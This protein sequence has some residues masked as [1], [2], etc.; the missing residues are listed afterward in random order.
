MTTF[1]N[2]TQQYGTHWHLRIQGIEPELLADLLE[3]LEK[4]LDNLYFTY[5]SGGLE[6]NTL[7]EGL[8]QQHLHLA[9]GTQRST[10]KWPIVNKLGLTDP[11]TKKLYTSWYLTPVYSTSS[12][13]KNRQYC[14]KHGNIVIDKGTLP[15]DD[16]A[17]REI[18]ARATQSRAKEKWTEMIKMAKNQEWNKLELEFP[19]EWINQGAKLKSLYLIQRVPEYR[20]HGNHLWIYGS[21]GTGKSAFVEAYY[22]NH[23][24]KRADKDWLGYNPDLE[25]GHRTVY[26]ADFDP[27]EM[28]KLT[29][30]V[31]KVM[32][33][34]QGFNA[35]KKYAGGDIIC[36]SQIIIT[37]NFR[38]GECFP[39]GVAGVEQQK[40]ALRRRFREVEASTLLQEHGIELKSKLELDQ[41]KN[42][43][44][45][46][47]MK[48][49]VKIAAS[50]LTPI[51]GKKR[52]RLLTEELIELHNVDEF[53][54]TV[55]T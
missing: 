16:I 53:L 35:D 20:E 22:P 4:G 23:Y 28:K 29:P 46:D 15:T 8:E 6:K 42:E 7:N 21:P 13:A 32:C 48:C 49:F 43:G 12:P 47:Y 18:G 17:V 2:D 5:A 51:T 55:P 31:L 41:L 30:Q 1:T 37:S 9:L 40:A 11:D 39:T 27:T 36:P 50:P 3:T 25:P 54:E 14:M 52:Q 24:K 26:L 10:K 38:L 44:N 34:P 45:F 33:D 19:Y